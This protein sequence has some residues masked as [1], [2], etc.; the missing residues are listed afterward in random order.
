ME[1]MTKSTFDVKVYP[2]TKQKYVVKVLDELSKNH[3]GSDKEKVSGHMPSMPESPDVCPVTTFEKYLAKLNP[4]QTGYGNIQ[5]TRLK[6]QMTAGTRTAPLVEI[7][8]RSSW[9]N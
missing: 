7:R 3:R 2:E 9:A 5:K 1:N 8:C 6:S 4:P